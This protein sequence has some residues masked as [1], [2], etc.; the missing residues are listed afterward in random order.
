MLCYEC[1]MDMTGRVF[2]I[3][4]FADGREITLCVF[5]ETRTRWEK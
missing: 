1:D 3:R 4:R 5:C 2:M